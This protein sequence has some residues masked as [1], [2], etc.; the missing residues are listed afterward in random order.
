MYQTT[1][2]GDKHKNQINGRQ[3][4]FTFS[5]ENII[6]MRIVLTL[7]LNKECHPSNIE[8][9][10]NDKSWTLTPE[11]ISLSYNI[12]EIVNRAYYYT[13]TDN[14][15]DNLSRIVKLQSG[16]EYELNLDSY[17]DENKLSNFMLTKSRC[18]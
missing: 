8:F 1:P 15:L 3:L 14:K 4:F 17:Y 12:E 16:K 10:Y 11:D 18:L 13:R 7:K 2:R 6:L 5:F 9:L